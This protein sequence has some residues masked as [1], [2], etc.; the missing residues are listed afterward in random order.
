MR[1]FNSGQDCVAPDVIFVPEQLKDRFH[2]RLAEELGHLKVGNTRDPNVNIGPIIKD[3]Y[4]SGIERWIHTEQPYVTY[5]GM[6]DLKNRYVYPTVV[7]KAARQH[8][9]DFLEFFAPIFYVLTYNTADELD[10]IFTSEQ[11]TEH[12]MYVTI[13]GSNTLL[14]KKLPKSTILRNVTVNDAEDG[15]SPY[16]GWGPKANLLIY[17]DKQIPR[18]ILITRDIYEILGSRSAV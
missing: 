11:F 15:N 8:T 9:G 14:E 2:A 6:L 13:F 10:H 5:G 4:V 1:C 16:G 3:T 12:S 7:T 18:P 17:G